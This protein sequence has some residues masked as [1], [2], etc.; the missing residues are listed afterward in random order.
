MF[1]TRND[2]DRLLLL[3]QFQD[4]VHV[5]TSIGNDCLTGEVHI[6]KHVIA[7]H[8]VV[9]IASGQFKTQWIAKCIHNGMDFSRYML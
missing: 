9:A 2:S 4:V 5:K 3:N 6:L 7:F 8:A 1:S